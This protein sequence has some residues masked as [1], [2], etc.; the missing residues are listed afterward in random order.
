MAGSAL[1]NIKELRGEENIYGELNRNS[2]KIEDREQR[3]KQLKT[4]STA[5]N[6]LFD[7]LVEKSDTLSD[8][9]SNRN[10]LKTLVD[11]KKRMVEINTYYKCSFAIIVY[12]YRNISPSIFAKPGFL[13][14]IYDKYV[15]VYRDG[16]W[17]A[18]RVLP[19]FRSVKS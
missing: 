2:G 13:E 14:H 12:I 18:N 7:D 16:H 9:K 15:G 10:E 17:C 3:L 4:L 6:S 8:L 11:G 19:H 1:D 5:R